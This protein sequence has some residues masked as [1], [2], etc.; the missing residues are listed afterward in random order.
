MP[1]TRG[2]GAESGST[3]GSCGIP[4]AT[5]GH[6]RAICAAAAEAKTSPARTGPLHRLRPGHGGPSRRP[7]GAEAGGEGV[8]WKGTPVAKIETSTQAG[9]PFQSANYGR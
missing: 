9:E 3:D 5:T 7:D 4:D 6:S 1:L 8:G 2:G